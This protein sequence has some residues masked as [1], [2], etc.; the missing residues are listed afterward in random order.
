MRN[1]TQPYSIRTFF[2]GSQAGQEG[3]LYLPRVPHP[4]V[5][6]LIHGGFWRMPYGREEITAIAKDIALRGYAVW[7]IEYRRIGAPGGG[8]PGTLHDIASAIDHLAVLAGN[9]IELDL[10]RVIVAG[11]SAG[12]Q[13]ALWAAAKKRLA[14]IFSPARVQPIAAAALAGV[15][16]LA[17]A[18]ELNSGRGAV[19]EFLG[20]SP[21]Q[22]P[23]RYT[24]ASPI[25][26]LPLGVRQLVIHGAKDEALPVELS[27]S[28]AAA[29]QA[30]GDSVEF[31]DL[32]D[33]GHKDFLDPNSNAYKNFC[34]WLAVQF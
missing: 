28:Y 9:G 30:S 17:R 22:Y 7:N 29:A 11:H 1:S 31:V 25:G 3:D 14:N 23:E 8:W 18:F 2:Y 34:E 4:P 24:A 15:T 10:N 27:R 6:C 19:N 5:V 32:P 12:G 20:G 21:A 26:L 16:D 33:A 13:L